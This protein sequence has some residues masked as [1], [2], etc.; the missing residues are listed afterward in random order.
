MTDQIYYRQPVFR[1]PSEG[2]SLLI[3]A[4][5]G[6]TYR[7]SFCVSN[8]GKHFE[9]R[10]I[11]EIKKDLHTAK[12]IYGLGVRRVFFLDGNAMVMP[13]SGLLEITRE[14][15]NVFPRLERVSVYAHAE[16]I[17]EKSDDELLQLSRAGL[18]MAYVGIETGNADLLRR[19]NKRTTPDSLVDAAQK[20]HKA[21][22]TLSG[23]I[24]L[25]LAGRDNDLSR[26][27]AID[28]AAV[29][30]KMC[31]PSQ[32][33]WYISTL[34]LMIPPGTPVAKQVE[35]G[36]F[37]PLTNLEILKELRLML[38]HIDDHL[39]SCVFRSNH[40]SNYLPLKGILARDKQK[41]LAQIE[42]GLHNPEN[43]RPEFF[44]GL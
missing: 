21:G 3:Q 23:T 6:C 14:A 35:K 12:R 34:A 2:R 13:F 26:A 16:D 41:L 37:E 30:N 38:T 27:H 18:R 22:I 15:F 4:T 11:Q 19:V 40:A 20:L 31:P 43:L 32:H 17:L 8:L 5:I 28:T 24:I 7:C 39:H 42:A 33:T 9:V 25:G 1:P 10:P 36:Q 44:R 29:V